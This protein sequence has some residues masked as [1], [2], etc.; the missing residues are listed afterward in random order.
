MISSIFASISRRVNPIITPFET[1]FMR[2]VKSRWKPAPSSS[3]LATRPL[4]RRRPSLGGV[5]PASTLS[6]VDLPAPFAPMRPSDAPEASR[7]STLRSAQNSR[8]RFSRPSEQASITRS[9]GRS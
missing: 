9:R 5:M 3:R 6:S 1:M 4:M 2:P 8:W 7:K